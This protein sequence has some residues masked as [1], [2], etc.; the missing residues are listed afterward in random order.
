MKNM[1]YSRNSPLK[2]QQEFE[3]KK[4]ISKLNTCSD[5]ASNPGVQFPETVAHRAY[6]P[7]QYTKQHTSHM[8][9]V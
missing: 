3:E 5:K 4:R 7:L 2:Y 6:S 1:S 8:E 9:C